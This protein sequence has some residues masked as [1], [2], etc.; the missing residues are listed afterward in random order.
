MNEYRR[1]AWAALALGLFVLEVLIATVWARVPVV[2]AD[3]GDYF[4]VLL[5]YAAA[6]TVRPF[7][8]TR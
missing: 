1:S 8:A 6:K 4:V 5:I 7:R 2:R 3:L